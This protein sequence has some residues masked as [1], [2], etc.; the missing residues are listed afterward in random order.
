M[1]Q[2]N[3]ITTDSKYKTYNILLLVS[4]LALLVLYLFVQSNKPINKVVKPNNIFVTKTSPTAPT[5]DIDANKDIEAQDKLI[6]ALVGKNEPVKPVVE[7]VK[8][9]AEVK[10]VAPKVVEQ[11][12]TTVRINRKI[13]ILDF[14]K[15]EEGRTV[16]PG[17]YVVSKGSKN[18][19]RENTTVKGNLY[20]V[21]IASNFKLPKGLRVEGHIYMK[22]AKAVRLN[23][24]LLLDGNIYV[25]ESAILPVAET[26]KIGG[27]IIL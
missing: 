15:K 24:D 17:D 2:V 20:I 16:I 4:V 8:E 19:L 23:E 18:I 13:V 5:E 21:N 11:P 22:N 6:G 7:E 1:T 26:A 27:Q 25:Y 10:P 14:G 3:Q 9:I 12:K